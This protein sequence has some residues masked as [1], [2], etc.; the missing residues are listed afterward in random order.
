VPVHDFAAAMTVVH[1]YTR[2]WRVED[3][4]HAWKSGVCDIERSQLRSLSAFRRWATIAAAVASR[5]ERLKT[6]SRSNPDVPA[7]SELSRFEIDAAI[8]LSE[9]KRFK[10]GADLTLE[11][12]VRLI[13]DIGGYTGKSSGGPPGVKV[14]ARGLIE[15]LAGARALKAYLRRSG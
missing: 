14:I 13:A 5:A 9:T 11:Q 12:A 2:R 15:V 4:H 10:K 8:L 3:F 7:L 1:A 6:T